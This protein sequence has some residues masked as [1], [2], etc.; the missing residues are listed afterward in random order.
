M[1]EIEWPTYPSEF[2]AAM[3]E[4]HIVDSMFDAVALRFG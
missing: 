1:H 4:D 3:A 2:V